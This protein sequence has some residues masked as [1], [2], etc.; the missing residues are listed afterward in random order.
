L[1]AEQQG[2]GDSQWKA[3]G[4]VSSKL[5]CTREARRRWMRQGERDRGARTGLSTAERGRLKQLGAGESAAEACQRDPAQG[6]GFLRAGGARPRRKVTVAFIDAHRAEY[7]VELICEELP[8]AP[9]TCYE[10]K[11]RERDPARL[12]ARLRRDRKLEHEILRAWHENFD[13]YGVRKTWQQ[14]N[15]EAVSV[16]RCTVGRLMR[17]PGL[18]GAVRSKAFKTTTPDRA[19]ARP[20]DL[21]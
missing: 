16:A 20:L 4:S 6:V 7:G 3:L 1:G 2:Q 8:I 17:R 5:G 18:R 19:A 14:L 10:A 15:R 12:P 11:A 13:V 21:V 9:S